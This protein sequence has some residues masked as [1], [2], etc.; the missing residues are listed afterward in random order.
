[1]K[2]E[3]DDVT[4]SEFKESLENLGDNVKTLNMYTNSPGG[5]VFVT[6]AMMS[7]LERI[8]DRITINA[9]ID[10]IAAS[11]AS[12]LVMKSHNIYMYK[13]SMMMVHKP[14][15]GLLFGE[16]ASISREKCESLN[17]M[18]QTTWTTAYMEKG[19]EHLTEQT[20]TG[21]L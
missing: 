8:K 3:D 4:I 19:T 10:G 7:Q 5:N 16:N 1:D 2:W 14:M 17:Q 9:Y 13:S 15:T 18:A 6:V 11:A 21:M 20:P 12:F